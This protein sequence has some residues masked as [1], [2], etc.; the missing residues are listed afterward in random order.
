MNSSYKPM[1]SRL[2]ATFAAGETNEPRFEKID[3][4]GLVLNGVQITL[5]GEALGHGVWLDREFC[6][7]VVEAGNKTGEAGVKVR[8]GHPSMCADALG[9]YLGRAK[10]FRLVELT[11]KDGTAACGVLADVYLD[12]NADR[13]EW[14][15]N[16]AES[17]PDTFGQSIVFTYADLKYLDADGVW[18]MLSDDGADE[19]KSVDGKLYAVL[20]KLH[21]TDF[22]DTPAATDGVF[23]DSDSLA[24][25]GENMLAEHPQIREVLEKSPKSV[26]EFLERTGLKSVIDAFENKR[27]AGCQQHEAEALAAKETE[28]STK[29]TAL[30]QERDDAVKIAADAMTELDKCRGDYREIVEKITGEHELSMKELTDERAELLKMNE[31]L[32]AK[33]KEFTE[34]NAKLEADLT[35]AK[36]A[37]DAVT[38]AKTKAEAALAEQSAA[39]ELSQQ[40]YREQIGQALQQP[41][42]G[43]SAKWSKGYA[44]YKASHS[45]K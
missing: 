28:W 41:T 25:E 21:G 34:M 40:R 45:S 30:C 42:E 17:A 22:T 5:E 8:F 36:T 44:S 4:E 43:K 9:T 26:F 7:A 35:A 16:M 23:A 10:C 19:S 11:R 24:A 29:M 32:E 13:T 31:A 39:L 27:V 15:M 37:F 20:G 6:S 14:I 1:K 38:E 12:P 18:H 33:V 2:R 3:K